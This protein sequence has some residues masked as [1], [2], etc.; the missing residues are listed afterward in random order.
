MRDPAT[1]FD[2]QVEA[3][4]EETCQFLEH[5]MQSE[6]WKAD[7]GGLAGEMGAAIEAVEGSDLPDWAKTLATWALLQ[8]T[9]KRQGRPKRT[10]RDHAIQKAAVR[11]VVRRGYRPTRNDQTRP[12]ASASSIIHHALHR[13]GEKMTE[14][15]INAVVGDYCRI[16][17]NL[18]DRDPDVLKYFAD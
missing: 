9:K 4:I 10:Y 14:K 7:P 17:L 16:W 5:H 18:C 12:R 11:L 6:F 15:R 2:P 8:Q 3:A 13:L 1:R